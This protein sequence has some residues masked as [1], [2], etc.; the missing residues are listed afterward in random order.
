VF[1]KG[2][3]CARGKSYLLKA[4]GESSGM[5]LTFASKLSQARLSRNSQGNIRQ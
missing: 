1:V 3:S 4:Q 5:S 2:P